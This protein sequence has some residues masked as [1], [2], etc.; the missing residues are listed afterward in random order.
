MVGLGAEGERMRKKIGKATGRL[1]L[2]D[3]ACSVLPEEL[4]LGLRNCGASVLSEA[5]MGLGV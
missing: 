4:H 2:A 5:K 3:V 1:K